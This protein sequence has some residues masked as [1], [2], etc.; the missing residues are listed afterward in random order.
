[1]SEQNKI[2]TQKTESTIRHRPLKTW[3]K[4][5]INADRRLSEAVAA[6]LAEVT[7]SG[8]EISS[9]NKKHLGN[10]PGGTEKYETITA[11]IPCGPTEKESRNIALKE[12]KLKSFLDGLLHIF[13]ECSMPEFKS[14][15]IHEEDWSKTWKSFFKSFQI[16]QSLI[17]KPTWEEANSKEHEKGGKHIIE[18]DPGLAFGTGHH[19]STQLALL[20]LEQL[21]KSDQGKLK[22]VLDVGTGSGIL[23]MGCALFGAERVLAIDNDPDAV[24]TAR[25]NIISNRLEHLIT[26][27]GQNIASI[28]SNFD[29]IVANITHDTL[30]QMAPILTGLLI[31]EGYLILA[32]ILKAK[33]ENSISRTYTGHGLKFINSLAKDEWVALQLQ[34][35]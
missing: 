22:N 23:A 8:I 10:D 27:S 15:L 19:A 20:L 24:E 32:G 26:V 14:E 35:K 25:N 7:N 9:P 12:E 18:M 21:Y 30:I 3:V 1:M 11:Y 29:L 16:T 31:P 5:T 28:K 17:I 33:Q 13:P 4:V 34:K 6:Y 2:S